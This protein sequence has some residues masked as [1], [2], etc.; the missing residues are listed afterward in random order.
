MKTSWS[1]DRNIL[2]LTLPEENLVSSIFT[3]QAEIRRERIKLLKYIPPWS[4]E[5]NKELEI[6]CRLEREKDPNLRTKIL[7]G[8]RDLK[9]SIKQKGE[10]FYKRVSVEYYGKLP[11]FNFT[12]VAEMS[13]G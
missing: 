11:G 1:Q 13:P 10:E 7:L 8:H 9:L 5:R 2:W 4:Y 3:R 12:K 6:L